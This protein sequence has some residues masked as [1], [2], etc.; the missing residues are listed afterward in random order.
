M[1]VGGITAYVEVY[2]KD[3]DQRVVLCRACGASSPPLDAGQEMDWFKR[4][5]AKVSQEHRRARFRR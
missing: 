2:G 1:A 4:H 3:G 5:A